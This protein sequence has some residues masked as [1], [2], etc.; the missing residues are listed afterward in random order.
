MI[1][2]LNDAI[3]VRLPADGYT[4]R[5]FGE[6]SIV[7]ENDIESVDLKFKTKIEFEAAGKCQ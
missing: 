1:E 7:T 6:F 2:R 5:V 3:S 4:L